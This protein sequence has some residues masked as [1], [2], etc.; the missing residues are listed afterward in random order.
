V[1]HRIPSPPEAV[2]ELKILSSPEE[3]HGSF[4]LVCVHEDGLQVRAVV[5]SSHTWEWQVLPWAQAATINKDHPEDDK[6]FL[7][8]TAG[9]LVNGRIYWTRNDY[10]IVLDTATLQFSSMDLPPST[11]GQKPFVVGETKD[12]KL[13]MVCA[14]DVELMIAVWV[15]RVGNPATKNSKKLTMTGPAT[16]TMELGGRV[17]R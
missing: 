16:P 9:N 5:F 4:R 7:P 3:R 13:C 17:W 11:A 6:H 12:E 10:L 8:P 1:L 2:R 14:I 15:W